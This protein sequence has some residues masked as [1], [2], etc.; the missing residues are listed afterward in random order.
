MEKKDFY[1]LEEECEY[2]FLNQGECYHLCTDEN[3]P[4]IFHNEQQFKTAMNVVALL[5]VITPEVEILTFEIMSNHMHFALCGE[6]KCILAWFDRLVLILKANPDLVESK[7]TIASLRAKVIPVDGLEYLR[8][9]IVYINRNG[10]IV[11]YGC[12]P[13]SYLWG[14]NRFFFNTEARLRY[15]L[16]RT[17]ATMRCKR[18]MFHS[19]LADNIWDIYVVDGYVSPL[20]FCKIDIAESLF[21]NAQ[22][23]FSKISR[24]IESSAMIARE[25]GESMY[26]L[27]S[28]LY[29]IIAMKC[30]K[31]F[32]CKSPA[33]IPADAKVTI[34]KMMRYDYNAS[35]KQ[36]ARILKIEVSTI[37]RLFPDI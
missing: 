4:V 17:K 15:E 28:E 7:D 30:S 16:S 32:G 22:H 31:E 19:N 11:D 10:F 37:K 3:C 33:Q 20:C 18:K 9:V 24:S 27:D 35:S 8:N 14:S 2:R 21:R 13:Y 23:Y 36:I 1:R 12:T 29:S 5:S 34:A 26:Y 25:I 6:R